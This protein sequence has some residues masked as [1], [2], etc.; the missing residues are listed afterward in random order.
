MPN[1]IFYSEL[2]YQLIPRVH[3]PHSQHIIGTILLD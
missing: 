2:E 1:Y 3:T